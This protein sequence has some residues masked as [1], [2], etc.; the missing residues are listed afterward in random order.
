VLF[1]KLSCGTKCLSV[2]NDDLVEG[3]HGG[4]PMEQA[5]V[6]QIGFLVAWRQFPKAVV[7]AKKSVDNLQWE[8]MV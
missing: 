6:R 1:Q 2:N 7:I 3:N 8:Q 5:E 4:G